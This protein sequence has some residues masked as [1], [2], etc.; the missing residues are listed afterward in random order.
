MEKQSQTHTRIMHA[1]WILGIH[2]HHSKCDLDAYIQVIGC[3][4]A[5]CIVWYWVWLLKWLG[6]ILLAYMQQVHGNIGKHYGWGIS[7]TEGGS[8]RGM[9]PTMVVNFGPWLSLPGFTVQ[10]ATLGML[11]VIN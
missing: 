8:Y 7:D 5:A 4:L 2:I 11:H 6:N 10:T 9:R 1:C 3:N